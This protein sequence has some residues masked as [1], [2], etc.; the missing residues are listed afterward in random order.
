MFA[1]CRSNRRPEQTRSEETGL[2]G[3]ARTY[4]ALG[5]SAVDGMSS[6]D[7]GVSSANAARET[8]RACHPMGDMSTH[9]I[10][11][12][13]SACAAIGAIGGV[14]ESRRKDRLAGL[15]ERRPRLFTVL[16][17]TVNR[18]TIAVG[19]ALQRRARGESA[20]VSWAL[21][22]VQPEEREN[23]PARTAASCEARIAG[24]HV[25]QTHLHVPAMDDG[26]CSS[27]ATRR[28]V[29]EEAE[30][31]PLAFL[32]HWNR[33][34]TA[35][36]VRASLAGDDPH[37]NDLLCIVTGTRTCTG[38]DRRGRCL[39]TCTGRALVSGLQQ[40]LLRKPSPRG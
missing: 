21:E 22:S 10:A 4:P 7:G 16:R 13:K 30:V 20:V 39:T 35:A 37:G 18:I 23:I 38:I 40:L 31:G 5:I 29:K 32:A 28:C 11:A 8:V 3:T 19:T 17:S 26:A 2:C 36:A 24:L 14:Q 15:A 12:G 6:D 1:Y 25:L 27:A 9:L 33:R 34:S